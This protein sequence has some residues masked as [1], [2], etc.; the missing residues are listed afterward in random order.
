MPALTCRDSM[1]WKGDEGNCP[2]RPTL[3]RGRPFLSPK[4]RNVNDIN[5]INHI[6]HFKKRGNRLSTSERLGLRCVIK[7]KNYYL[8][9]GILFITNILYCFEAKKRL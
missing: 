7:K 4:L 3:Y 9:I 8:Y 6:S 1:T 2:N 5:I